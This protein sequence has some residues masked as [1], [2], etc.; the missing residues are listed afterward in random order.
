M[1]VFSTRAT[2]TTKNPLIHHAAFAGKR[3]S[4]AFSPLCLGADHPS[5]MQKQEWHKSISWPISMLCLNGNLTM[6]S[7]GTAP[8][9]YRAAATRRTATVSIQ[10]FHACSGVQRCENGFIFCHFLSSHLFLFVLSLFFF[11]CRDLGRE[12]VNSTY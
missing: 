11:H 12:Y 8:S 3:L 10:D 2:R 6:N 1:T 5:V 9:Q 7:T 4:P